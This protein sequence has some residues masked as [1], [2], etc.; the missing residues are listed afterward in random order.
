MKKPG[1]K[2]IA[3]LISIASGLVGIAE[4]VFGDKI[5]AAKREDLKKEIIK[6]LTEKN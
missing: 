1:I 3:T 6:E 2:S 5:E 4:L